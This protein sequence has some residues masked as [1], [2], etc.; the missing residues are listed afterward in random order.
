M[1]TRA[2]SLTGDWQYVSTWASDSTNARPSLDQPSPPAMGLWLRTTRPVGPLP[3][4]PEMSSAWPARRATTL[5]WLLCSML[6]LASSLAS[7]T[8][9]R[10]AA[11]HSSIDRQGMGDMGRCQNFPKIRASGLLQGRR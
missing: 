4:S 9:V 1:H 6:D 11:S 10:D 7:P 8:S 5:V 3:V 2:A